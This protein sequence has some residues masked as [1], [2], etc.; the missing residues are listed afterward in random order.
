LPIELSFGQESIILT[1]RLDTGASNCIFQR[2]LAEAIGLEVEKGRKEIFNTV[3]G[4]FVAY[5]HEVQLKMLNCP[6]LELF[7]T[8]YFADNYSFRRDVI[9]RQGWLDRLRVAII[10]YE[11]KI[12][13]SDYNDK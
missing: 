10:D 6:E 4:N 5:G 2:S 9:G 11:A 13:L 1:A 7:T 3:T 12:F 8:V